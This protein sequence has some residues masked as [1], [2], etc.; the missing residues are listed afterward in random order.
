MQ[1]IKSDP[2]KF[3]SISPILVLIASNERRKY[4]F[5]QSFC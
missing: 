2:G 5:L 4:R 1:G 3:P